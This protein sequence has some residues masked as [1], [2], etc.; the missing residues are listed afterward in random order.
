MAR[1]SK[2]Q[3]ALLQRIDGGDSLWRHHDPNQDKWWLWLEGPDQLQTVSAQTARALVTR[4]LIKAR[5]GHV[6]TRWK[7]T[8]GG[9]AA[10]ATDDWKGT[11]KAR[12]AGKGK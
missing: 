6:H 11:R 12:L 8:T 2:P 10:L 4:G 9:R 7:L 1:L 3:H 5:S